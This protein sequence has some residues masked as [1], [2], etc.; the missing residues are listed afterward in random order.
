MHV[1][2]VNNRASKQKN[3]E[4]RKNTV[5][6]VRIRQKSRKLKSFIIDVDKKRK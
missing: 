3:I 2:N 6:K 4:K 1:I 5:K